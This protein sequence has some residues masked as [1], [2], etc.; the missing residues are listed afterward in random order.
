METNTEIDYKA[1]AERYRE[2]LND[3]YGEIETWLEGEQ[4][5]FTRGEMNLEQQNIGKYIA[6]TLTITNVETRELIAELKPGGAL[7]IAAEGRVDIIGDIDSDYLLYLVPDSGIDVDVSTKV[8]N[9]P[10]TTETKRWSVFRGFQH[11]G[12]YFTEV[13]RLARVKPINKEL[14]IDILAEVSYDESLA[15]A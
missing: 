4:Y 14:F 7:V 8:G 3:L 13:R 9:A 10:E 12:W 2:R 5:R 11:K 1:V 6:P 15:G